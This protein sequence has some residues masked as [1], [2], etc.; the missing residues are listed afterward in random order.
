MNLQK[1]KTTAENLAGEECMW[2]ILIDTDTGR[3]Y[4]A[5]PYGGGHHMRLTDCCG[6][7]STYA[8][9]GALSC[10]ACWHEVEPGEGDGMSRIHVG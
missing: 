4:D 3:K 5:E 10:K 2:D 7:Y 8:H 6:A 9:D 1:A